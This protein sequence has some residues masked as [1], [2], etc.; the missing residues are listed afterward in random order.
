MAID[1]VHTFQKCDIWQCSAFEE[2]L[3]CGNVFGTESVHFLLSE[4]EEFCFRFYFSVDFHTLCDCAFKTWN[5]VYSIRFINV[6]TA[7]GVESGFQNRI[8]RN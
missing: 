8:W 3:N 2:L 6:K 4:Y 7:A 1:L 5:K